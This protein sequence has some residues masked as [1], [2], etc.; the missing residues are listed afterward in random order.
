MNDRSSI[1]TRPLPVVTLPVKFGDTSRFTCP[2]FVTTC[3]FTLRSPPPVT[4]PVMRSSFPFIVWSSASVASVTTDAMVFVPLA[5]ATVAGVAPAAP[6]SSV[7]P[8]PENV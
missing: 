5:F 8:C 4:P 2:A 3:V 1:T 7:S 6:L